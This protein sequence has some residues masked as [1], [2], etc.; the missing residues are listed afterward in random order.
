MQFI[1]EEIGKYNAHPFL[2]DKYIR[3][4][5]KANIKDV[6]RVVLSLIIINYYIRFWSLN[7]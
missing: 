7:K 5:D 6:C 1:N 3:S 2:S 4:T